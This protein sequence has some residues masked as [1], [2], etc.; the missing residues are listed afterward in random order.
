MEDEAAGQRRLSLGHQVTEG[1]EGA[2]G[3]PATAATPEQPASLPRLRPQE[4]LVDLRRDR[5]VTPFNN[6]RQELAQV[7]RG[8]RGGGGGRAV[9][10]FASAKQPFGALVGFHPSSATS[11]LLRTGV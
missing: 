8:R 2:N 5:E 1:H 6:W 10:T 9:C 11:L 3:I 4:I 7:G